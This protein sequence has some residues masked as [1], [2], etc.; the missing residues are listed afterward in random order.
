VETFL[1]EVNKKLEE[2]EV[3]TESSEN[4]FSISSK[5][6]SEKFENWY[7]R[8]PLKGIYWQLIIFCIGVIWVIGD[9]LM[10]LFS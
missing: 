1:K 4:I 3:K 6:K 10:Y 9:V 2:K 5:L 7:F 8:P